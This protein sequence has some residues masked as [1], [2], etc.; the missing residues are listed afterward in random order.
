MPNNHF[1]WGRIDAL[2]AYNLEPSLN[3]TITFP[4]IAGKTFGDPD[5][6]LDA[7]ASSART[8]SYA[9]AGNCT[10]VGGSVHITGAGSCTVTASQAGLDAYDIAPA[11]P[12]PYYAAPD[13]VR[14]FA[15]AKA[16]QTI[17]F[18]PLADKTFGVDDGDFDVSA[19]ATS[20]LPVSFAAAGPCTVTG[21]TVDITGVGD[22]TI[23]ASQA[24]NVNYEAAP[25][26]SRT[27][28]TAWIFD[29]LV[30]PIGANGFSGSAGGTTLITFKLGDNYGLDVLAAGYPKSK[31]CGAADSTLVS[32]TSANNGLKI[33]SARRY[34][35]LLKID[36]AW[37]RT[38]P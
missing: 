36:K 3:Q 37:A 8:V 4:A 22:C 16:S 33:T 5:V 34:E 19:T 1:G 9:V 31:Q 14:T 38:V 17:A 27:F 10:L 15:I 25:S 13:V 32:T 20:G 28:R 7:T 23:T 6:V 30:W 11:A 29:G 24:G 21:V 12:V 2:A 18:G 35:Y 26:V